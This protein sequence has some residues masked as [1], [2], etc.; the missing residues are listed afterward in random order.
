LHAI[1]GFVSLLELKLE[2]WKDAE[3]ND[4]LAQIHVGV[5]RMT[6]L[7]E[8]LLRLARIAREGLKTEWVDLTRIATI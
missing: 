3:A 8:D 5:K 4:H 7:T 2:A 6:D 1:D